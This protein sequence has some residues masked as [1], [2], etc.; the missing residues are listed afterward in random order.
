MLKSY[1]L[2][3][4]WIWFMPFIVYGINQRQFPMYLLVT[5]L[6]LSRSNSNVL[7]NINNL[8]WLFEKAKRP[9]FG[10]V[11]ARVQT[12]SQIHSHDDDPN[13]SHEIRLKVIGWQSFIHF[14]LLNQIVKRDNRTS[15]FNWSRAQ[16]PRHQHHHHWHYRNNNNNHNHKLCTRKNTHYCWAGNVCVCNG[17]KNKIQRIALQFIQFHI[18]LIN[19][20][21]QQKYEANTLYI[22]WIHIFWWWHCFRFDI[23]WNWRKIAV[24][25][26]SLSATCHQHTYGRQQQQQ[27]VHT[28]CSEK[29]C[30][31]MNCGAIIRKGKLKQS[32]CDELTWL[33]LL[34]RII[35]VNDELD[36]VY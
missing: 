20:K 12:R 28:V 4:F 18:C 27:Q 3:C 23:C 33:C 30:S 1:A 25:H 2:A 10:S 17:N 13:C 5:L 15:S 16:M 34:Q 6:E 14:I 35:T 26:V 19:N 36:L 9:E 31:K 21:K 11:W 22:E 7:A 8:N 24:S 32:S 29:K